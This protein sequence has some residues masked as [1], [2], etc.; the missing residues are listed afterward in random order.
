MNR[1]LS[2]LAVV[3]AASAVAPSSARADTSQWQRAV[4]VLQYLESDYPAAVA[5]GSPSELEEQRGFAHEALQLIQ[6]LGTAGE[7][8]VPRMQSIADRIDRGQDP[9]GV[10]RDCSALVENLVQAGAL[11]RSPRHPPDLQQGKTLYAQDCAVCHGAGGKADTATAQRLN[12]HPA[13]F[14]D[15]EVMASLTP[16]KAFNVMTFGVSGTP[17]PAYTTL[18]EEQR[19]ALAFYLFTFRQPP[20][21]HNPPKV[22]LEA[23]ATSSDP[24][25]AK[26]YG[27]KE[28]ACLRSRFPQPDEER[29]LLTA[30]DGVEKALQLAS[31]GKRGQATQ[32]LLDAYLNGVEPVEGLLNARNPGVVSQ[33]EEAFTQTRLEAEHGDPK[34]QETGKRLLSLIDQAR[35]S[36][37]ATSTF[38]SVFWLAALVVVREGFEA[39]IVI[40]ALLAVL[41]KMK[42][43]ESVRT[44]HAGWISALVVGAVAF[45]IGHKLLG[46]AH[47][48]L[49]EGITA[50]VAVAM[51]LYAA[52]WLNAKSN[53][54]KW[55]GELRARMQTAL[56]SGSRLGLF[57][58]AFTAVFRESFECALFLQGLSVDSPSGASWGALL[59]LLTMVALVVFVKTVGFRLPMK[60]LFSVST[61]LLFLTAVVLLGEGVHSLQEVGVLPL[62]RIPGP[63][64][65]AL[66]LYPDAYSLLPQAVLLLSV[67][68]YQWWK[69][70]DSEG[71]HGGP[72]SQPQS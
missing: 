21:D 46:G 64:V 51:L 38:L 59:G 20:C 40:A 14:F 67:I 28:L 37:S 25:L 18:S 35:R 26:Q 41:K 57:T 22:S 50:L 71:S 12:P 33:I 19:W 56:G 6:Q 4:E 10:R 31:E 9:E 45:A 72:V 32:T 53:I 54:R 16:Y 52:L 39:T 23:L 34:V 70:R 8:F 27:E 60:A 1:S 43:E 29:S 2:V 65:E 17:M 15:P 24:Q 13:S 61:V 48:E 30:R 58:I 63:H 3:M 69:R 5:S 36:S 66:G 62:A 55:M 42:A 44:V 7:P 68:P 47:R 11:A 49:L